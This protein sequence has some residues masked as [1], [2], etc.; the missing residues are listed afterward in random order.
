M[1][2]FNLLWGR[3]DDVLIVDATIGEY[4]II[5]FYNH[6]DFKRPMAVDEN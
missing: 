2:Y 3:S 5:K 4:I 6:V 1:T